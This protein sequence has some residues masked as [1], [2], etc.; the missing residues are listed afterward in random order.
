MIAFTADNHIGVTTQWSIKERGQDFMDSFHDMVD[1]LVKSKDKES[2]LIIGGDLFDT[3]YPP[4]HAVA[5]VQR[6]VMRLH[7]HRCTVLGIDGNHDVSDG[8][9]LEVCGICRLTDVPLPVVAGDVGLTVCGLDYRRAAEMLTTLREMAD[10][11]VKCDILVL[12]L[13]LGE[14][15]RMGAAS[16]VTAAEMMPMLKAM[17]VRLV[18]L[19]HIHIR[20]S[21]VVDGVMFAYCGSTE[22]CSMNEQKDKSFEVI[23]PVT[24]ELS[25]VGIKTR[26]IEHVVISTEKEFSAFEARI[27]EGASAGTLFSAFITPD[28]TDGVKRLRAM[29]TGH[30]ALM[31][32]QVMRVNGESGPS[33]AGAI[34]RTTGIIGLEQAI[35]LSFKPD[36]E[37]AGLI[38]AILRTPDSLKVTVD[39]YMKE[40]G[41]K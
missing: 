22:V 14:L 25:H 5:F 21:T 33:V 31:R 39:N 16:D 19:G 18:L 36:S 20:Q 41:A 35:G 17:G 37:E 3:P 9:W 27:D 8:H 12:H 23:D 30:N 10:R 7:R 26:P 6:E 40:G 13:A 24:L 38:K 11:D 32:I 2:T 4:A 1:R 29:A 34:D 28:V 15:N